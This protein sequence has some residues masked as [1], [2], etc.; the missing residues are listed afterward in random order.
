MKLDK[1]DMLVLAAVSVLTVS[2]VFIGTSGADN[3]P[4]PRAAANRLKSEPPSPALF[5]KSEELR[6]LVEAGQ[7]GAALEGLKGLASENPAMSEP[8]ALMGEAYSRMLDYP[9]AMKEYRIALMLDPDYVDKNSSKFI[10]KRIKAA[11]KEGMEG[12]KAAL[13]RDKD[14]TQ[15]KAAL[16]DAYYLERMLAG[17]CE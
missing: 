13:A 1:F 17:G 15:A 2:A 7:P 10:G 12:S 9:S 8:H 11:M 6:T 4:M 5:A 14:D 3:G 16:K